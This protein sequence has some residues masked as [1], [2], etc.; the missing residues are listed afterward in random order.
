LPLPATTTGFFH[1]TQVS[2][3][4]PNVWMM[5]PAVGAGRMVMGNRCFVGSR[6]DISHF[7]LLRDRLPAAAFF[8]QARWQ[9]CCKRH[10]A[11]EDE[12][13]GVA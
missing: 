12:V 10:R 9:V 5:T 2:G 6:K 4:Q 7:T 13:P 8:L 1:A 3:D 11:V